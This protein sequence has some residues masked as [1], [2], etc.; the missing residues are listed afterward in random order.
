MSSATRDG[1]TDAHTP[2]L[3][4]RVLTPL[5]DL[6]IAAMTREKTWRPALVK[7]MAPSPGDRILDIGSGTGS[8]AVALLTAC[9]QIRYVGV[10]PDADA[11]RQARQ[12]LVGLEGNIRFHE[13]YFSA[14]DEY[15][16]E[17]PN[18]IV[19]SLV[20]H[21]VPL[22]EKR[23]IIT[24]AAKALA[25]GG[26]L[27]IADYGLQKGFQRMLFRGTVQ[28]LDGVEDTQPNAEGII[29]KLLEN[30]GFLSVEEI[31]TFATATGTI[32]IY[33]ACPRP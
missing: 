14:G 11:V 20:L 31:E 22:A 27:F 4:H 12:K 30:T 1:R 25:P 10:D 9:P 23:R 16:S 2:P 3:G 33:F 24:Q 7:A 26:S 8:L 29:P 19:S 17:A 15:F 28:A 5:Y 6:A 21:Q 32:S 18:K 13:G